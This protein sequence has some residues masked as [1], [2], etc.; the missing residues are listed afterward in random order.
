[1]K[2]VVVAVAAA[3]AAKTRPFFKGFWVSNI[4]LPTFQRGKTNG[5]K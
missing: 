2:T 1:M 4:P 3:A 5:V